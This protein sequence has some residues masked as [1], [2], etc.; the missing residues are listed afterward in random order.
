MGLEE[1]KGPKYQKAKLDEA[2]CKDI[3]TRMTQLMESKKLYLN[4]ELK[5]ADIALELGVSPS[6]LSQVI[7]LYMKDNYYDF[8]N[9]FRMEEFKRMIANEEYR[10]YTLTA[11]SER[12]GFKK[13]SFFTTFRKVEGMTPTEYLKSHNISMKY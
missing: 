11:L 10:R 1:M 9:R 13:T 6:K 2:D 8:V 4:P 7:S 3:A 12:C 5:R